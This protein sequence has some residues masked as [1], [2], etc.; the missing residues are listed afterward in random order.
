MPDSL[1][2]LGQAENTNMEDHGVT[3]AMRREEEAIK[4]K[5]NAEEAER[6]ELMA[7]ERK[8]FMDEGADVVE[9]KFKDLDHL[10]NQ[11]KVCLEFHSA[12]PC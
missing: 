11:S 9:K 7:E 4:Q 1:P 2:L 10:L 6:D 8:K 3:E 5:L 12:D